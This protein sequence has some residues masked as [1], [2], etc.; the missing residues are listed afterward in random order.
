MNWTKMMIPPPGKE[1]NQ[2]MFIQKQTDTGKSNMGYPT[3]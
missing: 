2:L 3:V 1:D